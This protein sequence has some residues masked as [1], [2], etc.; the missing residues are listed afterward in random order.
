MIV[1]I[2]CCNDS[3]EYAVTKDFDKAKLKM[4]ELKELDFRKKQKESHILYGSYEKIYFWHIHKI[5]GE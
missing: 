4:Q 3:I 1:Y 5:E 2:I